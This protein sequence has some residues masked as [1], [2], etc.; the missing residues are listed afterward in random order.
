MRSKNC[1]V[2]WNPDKNE[3][4][5][6]ASNLADPYGL[7]ID[8]EGNLLIADKA[9]NRICRLRD[10]G[11]KKSIPMIQ[12]GIENTDLRQDKTILILRQ[13]FFV[14]QKETFWFAI[15]MI[16]LSIV[17]ILMEDWNLYWGYLHHGTMFL[18][19]GQS[20]YL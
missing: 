14:R 16:I 17:F 1:V 7:D 3:F 2:C 15:A 5:I 20:K 9:H 13:E 19:E 11:L 4:E 12:M 18:V 6:V 8:A 10:G